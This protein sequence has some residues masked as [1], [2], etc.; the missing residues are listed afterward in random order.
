MQCGH[1]WC[2][3][4]VRPHAGH[5]HS[6]LTSLSALP[7]ICRERF[8][9]CD[10]FF[11]GT[12]RR[13]DSQMSPS[14]DGRDG[15]EREMAGRAE[16]TGVAAS[17]FANRE[18]MRTVRD[19]INALEATVDVKEVDVASEDDAKSRWK[20]E[21]EPAVRNGIAAAAMADTEY[22]WVDVLCGGLVGKESWCVAVCWIN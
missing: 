20:I 17:R 22:V 8:F 21:A 4:L 15:S 1:M 5:L 3:R 16:R 19:D 2:I 6:E 10:V 11:F 12:A 14:S 13:I 9:E 7:A 18:A